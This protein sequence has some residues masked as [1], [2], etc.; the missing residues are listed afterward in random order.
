MKERTIAGLRV[1][2]VGGDDRAG[3][4]TGPLVVLLHG[5]G[6]P[7]DDLVGLHRVVAA[8]PGTRFFFPEAPLEL[9]GGYGEG[10]AWWNI[11]MVRLQVAMMTGQTRDLTHEV[12]EGLEAA[13]A[14]V[15][16]L[17]DAVGG[18]IAAPADGRL[19]LGGFSQG[20]MLSLDVALH[21]K[22]ALSGLVLMSGTLIAESEWTPL[23]ASRRGLPVLQ[24]HGTE[25]PLLPFAIAERL[26]DE[27][28]RA[29]LPVTWVPFRG[30]HG[31][32]P[33]VTDALGA[34]VQGPAS[35]A[36]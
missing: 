8:P 1:R 11:D 29:G 5:Y 15:S 10:R 28:R 7:G 17:L 9:G 16:A 6:A 33:Q 24:S 13:R 31:V 20:A 21:G 35:P 36:G 22:H 26:R 27:L 32:A 14:G 2:T 23:F 34:F 19:F 3:G 4:G 30:G 18:D 12:P 25:D